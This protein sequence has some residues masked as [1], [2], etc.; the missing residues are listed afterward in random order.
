[1]RFVMQVRGLL[2]EAAHHLIRRIGRPIGE[3]RDIGRELAVAVGLGELALGECDFALLR[4]DGAGAQHQM[5]K[6]DVEF[7]RRHIGT[8]GHETHVAQRAGVDHRL[9]AF[10]RDGI[11]FAGLRFVDE[12]EEARKGIAEIEAAAARMADIEDAPELGIELGFV[13]KF[14]VFPG[15]RMPCRCS[16]AAFPHDQLFRFGK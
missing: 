15:K 10:A 16:E 3:R 5:R 8:F 12:I 4:F 11:E 1:M 13:V 14:R 6:I 7:M 9:E 2:E